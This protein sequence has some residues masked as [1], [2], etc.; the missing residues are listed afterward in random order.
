MDR[1]RRS[2]RLTHIFTFTPRTHQV[3]NLVPTGSDR[4]AT[5]S[6]LRLA[7]RWTE[8]AR[9]PGL[10]RRLPT[11]R[12]RFRGRDKKCRA[13]SQRAYRASVPRNRSGSGSGNRMTAGAQRHR[14]TRMGACGAQ[15][16]EATLVA[17][18]DRRRV[19]IERHD[20]DLADPHVRR[21]RKGEGR[22]SPRGRQ[23]ARARSTPRRSCE[24]ATHRSDREALLAPPPHPR[25]TASLAAV[26]KKTRRPTCAGS[27]KACTFRPRR[28]T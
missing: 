11:R 4:S 7:A 6:A 28:R 18:H 26:S 12:T 10:Q 14:A 21:P 13:L 15:R 25:T 27:L 2:N 17:R 19:V 1:E 9:G 16:V 5:T 20:G 22:P 3:A 24:P 23:A 8:A